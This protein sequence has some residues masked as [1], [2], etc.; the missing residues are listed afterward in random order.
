M[1]L[2]L[3]FI[4]PLDH[5]Y[6]DND[7]WK[8]R[9]LQQ[10]GIGVED[11]FLEAMSYKLRHIVPVEL[12]WFQQYMDVNQVQNLWHKMQGNKAATAT[13]QGFTQLY[14]EVVYHIYA[15]Y[16]NYFKATFD[17]YGIEPDDS[18]VFGNLRVSRVKWLDPNNINFYLLYDTVDP[19]IS[20]V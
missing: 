5:F 18:N 14:V 3:N 12:V 2:E 20:R 15:S 8:I 1:R 11:L 10:Y 9:L 6:L 7:E 13:L 19:V 16:F 17:H 4:V